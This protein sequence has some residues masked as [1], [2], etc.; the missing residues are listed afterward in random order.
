MR[1]VKIPAGVGR[2]L[3]DD[4]KVANNP[5]L[6]PLA[7]LKCLPAASGIALDTGNGIQDVPKALFEIPH[8]GI[9]SR[10]T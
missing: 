10:S 3:A 8:R 6:N 4:L 9:A 5:D 1:P 7:L 2:G